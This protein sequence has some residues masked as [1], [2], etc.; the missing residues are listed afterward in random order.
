MIE[1]LEDEI[2]EARVM[3]NRAGGGDLKTLDNENKR[4]KDELQ[5]LQK[6][7]DELSTEMSE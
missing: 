4:M 2:T 6:S 7:Y 5:K 3:L 1:E